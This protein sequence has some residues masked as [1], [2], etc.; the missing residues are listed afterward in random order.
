MINRPLLVFILFSMVCVQACSVAYFEI[1]NPIES[2]HT[3]ELSKH[4]EIKFAI[5]V[6][7]DPRMGTRKPTYR[8]EKLEKD[9]EEY[10]KVTN[11]TFMQM[12]FIATH[13]SDVEQAN[14]KISILISPYWSA[15]PQ[16]WL[17]G[18]SFGLIPSSGTREKE[19]IFAF[20]D[21]IND[22]NHAYLI[23]EKTYNH[24]LLFPA[25]VVSLASLDEKEVFKK[26]LVNFIENS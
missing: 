5:S 25:S 15:L 8:K 14:F 4:K 16:E 23:D 20:E 11:D 24:I 26:A 3:G 13:V 7:A 1:S 12:G 17:T 18:L 21:M 2:P 6:K 10:I 19:Y 9:I 22:R